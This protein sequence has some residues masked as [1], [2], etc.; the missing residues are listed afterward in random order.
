M[1]KA[2]LDNNLMMAAI[3]NIKEEYL[4]ESMPTMALINQISQYE[5]SN[6]NQPRQLWVANIL[7]C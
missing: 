7:N 4:A 1:G 3:N 5:I 2:L 6:I